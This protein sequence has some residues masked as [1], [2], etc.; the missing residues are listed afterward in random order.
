MRLLA[1]NFINEYLYLLIGFYQTS[2]KEYILPF[3]FAFL[4]ARSQLFLF[5]EYYLWDACLRAAS[6]ASNCSLS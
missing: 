6:A 1:C 2:Q 4:K 3:W 5:P